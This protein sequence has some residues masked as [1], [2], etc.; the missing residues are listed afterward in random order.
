MATNEESIAHLKQEVKNFTFIRDEYLT[1][2]QA[3]FPQLSEQE[4]Y[5]SSEA[6]RIFKKMIERYSIITQRLID[7]GG[8]YYHYPVL[9]NNEFSLL[10]KRYKV[11]PAETILEALKELNDIFSGNYRWGVPSGLDE[12]FFEKTNRVPLSLYYYYFDKYKGQLCRSKE[13]RYWFESLLMKP[14]FSAGDIVSLRSNPTDNAIKFEFQWSDGHGKDLRTLYPD[15]DFLNKTFM[16]LGVENKKSRYYE[17]A[18][19][20]NANGGMRRYKVLPIG[21]TTV[22]WIIERALKKNRT[23]AVKDAKRT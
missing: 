19:K 15:A 6:L 12:Q 5:D 23:K 11:Y 16:V 7:N 3:T 1:E 18:Y 2:L 21:D 20:P 9:D 14:K 17:K 10:K 8:T 22:Y 13:R 4:Y